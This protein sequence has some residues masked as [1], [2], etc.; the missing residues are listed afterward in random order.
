[1]NPVIAQ[2][3]ATVD[4]PVWLAQVLFTLVAGIIGWLVVR[5]LNQ[6]ERTMQDHHDDLKGEIKI[7]RERSHE[8]ANLLAAH[9][10]K[11]EKR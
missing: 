4:V 7:L 8:H 2:A 3:A 6:L 1:M 11:L 5:Q 9:T 10:A